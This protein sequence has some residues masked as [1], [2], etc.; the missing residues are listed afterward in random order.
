MSAPDGRPL[1]Q[2]GDVQVWSGF[3]GKRRGAL[4]GP[5]AHGVDDLE[6]LV[7]DADEVLEQVAEG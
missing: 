2:A 6:V 4:A 5:V 3:T 1:T 7:I